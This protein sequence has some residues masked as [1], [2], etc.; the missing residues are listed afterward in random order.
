MLY[1]RIAKGK[2]NRLRSSRGSV[3]KRIRASNGRREK[4]SSVWGGRDG[5][6]KAARERSG[7][8]VNRCRAGFEGGAKEKKNED[9]S[10]FRSGEG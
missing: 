3:K 4:G 5:G 6:K 8:G 10:R 9:I 1:S 7:Q 2:N